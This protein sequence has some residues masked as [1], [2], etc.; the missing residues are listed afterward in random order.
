MAYP[1]C[2]YIPPATILKYLAEVEALK[3]MFL[4]TE[5]FVCP[6]YS[7]YLSS[8]CKCLVIDVWL[9]AN[10]LSL[11]NE[12]VN[13]ALLGSSPVPHA[14]PVQVGAQ[15]EGKWW[16]QNTT[17]IFRSACEP[18]GK[19]NYTPL[20]ML[21]EIRKKKSLLS[22]LFDSKRGKPEFDT[23]PVEGDNLWVFPI[24]PLGSRDFI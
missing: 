12:T 10:D 17:G 6:A 11:A 24:D 19:D 14:P 15:M 3:D 16:T 2:S 7:L 9:K 5:V 8:G 18:H 13:L 21:K 23:T 4:V 1:R 20:Y 22:S